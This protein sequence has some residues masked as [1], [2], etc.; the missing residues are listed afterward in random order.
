MNSRCWDLLYY[1]DNDLVEKLK[2]QKI[3]VIRI[4]QDDFE[5]K[6]EELSPV[7]RFSNEFLMSM[8]IENL[9]YPKPGLTPYLTENGAIRFLKEV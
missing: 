5:K 3:N 4:T 2:Y 6:M 8:G 1:S 7:F 9:Y